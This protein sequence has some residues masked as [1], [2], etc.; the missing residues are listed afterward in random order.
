VSAALS[1]SFST[2]VTVRA[3]AVHACNAQL[4]RIGLH[5]RPPG[6]S[7]R[8]DRL[9]VAALRAAHRARPGRR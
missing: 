6:R 7:V 1:C 8:R 5:P 2:A 3:E 4:R 9:K